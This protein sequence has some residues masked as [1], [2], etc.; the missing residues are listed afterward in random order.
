MTNVGN[1][2]IVTLPIASST[3]TVRR[4]A[5][6]ASFLVQKDSRGRVA[7]GSVMTDDRY[8]VTCDA[9]GRIILEPAV[10]MT[11]TEHRL[12]SDPDFIAQ[13]SQ[14]ADAPSVRIELDEI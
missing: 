3:G 11:A 10:V 5:T 8:L 1:A 9:D 7:L 12:L 13:M 2:H 14:A 6:T 4:M